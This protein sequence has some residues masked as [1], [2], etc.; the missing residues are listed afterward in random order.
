MPQVEKIL[1]G[2]F[3]SW[4]KDTEDYAL[5]LPLHTVREWPKDKRAFSAMWLV[6][7]NPRENIIYQAQER[8]IKNTRVCLVFTCVSREMTPI[9]ETD[10]QY[11]PVCVCVWKYVSENKMHWCTY[12]EKKKTMINIFIINIYF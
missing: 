6:L 5:T 10:P 9:S 4:P 2:G 1:V 12:L 7:P 3:I 8:K 11:V